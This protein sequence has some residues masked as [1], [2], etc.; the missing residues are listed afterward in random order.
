MKGEITF[1]S[2]EEKVKFKNTF[3][4][5][6]SECGYFTKYNIK[7]D[8]YFCPDCD[9]WCEAKCSDPECEFCKHRPEKPSDINEI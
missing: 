7:Y 5:H 8:A 2:N 1:D 4:C 6:C 9:I 3:T